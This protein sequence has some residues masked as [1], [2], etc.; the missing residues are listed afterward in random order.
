MNIS[1]RRLKEIIKEEVQKFEI[2]KNVFEDEKEAEETQ[3]EETPE[4]PEFEIDIPSEEPESAEDTDYPRETLN[5]MMSELV[6]KGL[7]RSVYQVLDALS[8]SFHRRD[9]DHLKK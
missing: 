4:E 6:S 8:D 1:K 7:S 9:T 5:R 2:K 3:A